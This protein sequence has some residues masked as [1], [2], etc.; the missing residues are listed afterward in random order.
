MKNAWELT[1]DATRN[2]F[3]LVILPPQTTETKFRLN[4]YI[5]EIS[6]T[7]YELC[8]SAK[9]AKE[10][11]TCREKL[12]RPLE[13]SLPLQQ[14]YGELFTLTRKKCL[15]LFNPPTGWMILKLFV[16]RKEI[17]TIA[18]DLRSEIALSLMAHGFS[19]MAIAEHLDPISGCFV[20][21]S[22]N[23]TATSTIN[24]NLIHLPVHLGIDYD[25]P[26]F[27]TELRWG[28]SYNFMPYA[29]KYKVATKKM[30]ELMGVEAPSAAD[31]LDL[32]RPSTSIDPS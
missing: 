16:S 17:V 1:Q 22:N 20:R 2:G 15:V 30:A 7:P 5:I 8:V 11:G 18:S 24:Q 6:P 25:A 9:L 10:F 14:W 19:P 31:H 26:M 13:H 21:R 3:T 12:E 29:G 32:Y 28:K 23:R 27:S 4:R